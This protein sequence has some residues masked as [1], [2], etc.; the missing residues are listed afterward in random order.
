M[1]PRFSATH[2]NDVWECQTYTSRS[3]A[4]HKI[5]TYSRV[6]LRDGNTKLVRGQ[7]SYV[8]RDLYAR[9]SRLCR[10]VKRVSD[11]FMFVLLTQM[12]GSMGGEVFALYIIQTEFYAAMM[13][14]AVAIMGQVFLYCYLGDMLVQVVTIEP[15]CSYAIHA[16]GRNY[17][18]ACVRNCAA[19]RE[20]NAHGPQADPLPN[21]IYCSGWHRFRLTE[22]RHLQRMMHQAQ[23]PVFLSIGRIG[24]LDLPAFINVSV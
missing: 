5:I 4:L 21:Q 24:K 2:M 7:M 17:N 12:V 15:C 9:S 20:T 13:F 1:Y 3:S 6:R 8:A 16:H 11:M 23:R 14:S 10:A 22:Q 19:S 18:A